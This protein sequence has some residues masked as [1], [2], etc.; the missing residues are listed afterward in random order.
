[1]LERLLDIER[2]WFFA[3]N[4]SHTWYLD[5]VMLAFASV[6]AWFPLVL[7]V[8]FFILKRRKDWLLML[9]FTILSVV[10]TILLTEVL[11]KPYFM[12]F[13]PTSH[14][15]FMDDVRIFNGYIADG[16]YGFFSGHSA[17]AF[18]FAVMSAL[19]IKNKWQQTLPILQD[20]K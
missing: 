1:M 7:V 4:G 19:L 17:S 16:A 2:D 20:R 9:V 14:P 13:R 18:V 6:W 10:T 3:I 5:Y 12:R 11:I 8:L 15:L